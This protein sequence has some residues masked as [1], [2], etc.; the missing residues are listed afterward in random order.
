[1]PGCLFV[2]HD[3]RPVAWAAR[4]HLGGLCCCRGTLCGA[5]GFVNLPRL[6]SLTTTLSA[7]YFKQGFLI[8][9]GENFAICV[10]IEVAIADL[11]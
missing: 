9:C 10:Q 1:M 6:F 2:F 7:P 5:R 4:T 3:Q 8:W 11:V